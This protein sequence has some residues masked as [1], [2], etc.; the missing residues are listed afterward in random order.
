[1]V[2]VAMSA[3]TAPRRR[4][5]G[6]QLLPH[7]TTRYINGR[8]VSN[9]TEIAGLPGARKWRSSQYNLSYRDLSELRTIERRGEGA[10][11]G[12]DEEDTESVDEKTY[13]ISSK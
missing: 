6:S 8:K 3:L 7:I 13:A 12:G 11:D 2:N 4:I 1:M 5:Q 10:D 9:V